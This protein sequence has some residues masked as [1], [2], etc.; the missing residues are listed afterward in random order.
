MKILIVTQKA[1]RT[2]PILGFFHRWV[3]ELAKRCERVIVVAQSEG[4][5]AFPPNV[6]VWSLGKEKG[7]SRWR[8]VARFWELQWMLRDRYDAAFVHMTPVWVVLG[9]KIWAL[10]RTP[11]FLWYEVRRGGRVLRTAVKIARKVFSATA[12]GMPFPSEKTLVVGHG[13]DTALFRP[14][15]EAERDPHL[16]LTV[17]R[18]T[19]IKRFDVILRALADL[20]RPYRLLIGGGPVLPSDRKT[21]AELTA[22]L[23]ENEME[24]RV[25]I[26]FL[27]QEEVAAAMRRARLFLHA[28]GGGLD[29]VVL[30]AMAS[31]CPILSCGEAAPNV[32]PAS[33]LSSPEDFPLRAAEMLAMPDLERE[34]MQREL[35]ATIE[36]DHALARLA[37]R[38]VAEMDAR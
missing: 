14:G 9:A 13:I 10:L 27:S 1:D 32:L 37:D 22:F 2:D 15:A 20:P 12:D 6:E 8:Q 23:R 33:C 34:D 19:P 18:V 21:L 24:D 28:C 4:E 25:E 36:R 5:H 11:V 16:L 30:E 7:Y 38:L 17:G 35:R 31:G 26:R 29:K 3:E